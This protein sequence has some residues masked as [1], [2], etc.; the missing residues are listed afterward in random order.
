MKNIDIL[1]DFTQNILKANYIPVH[2]ITFPCTFSDISW[3][4]LGLRNDFFEEEI[5]NANLNR[6]LMSFEP[7][8]IYHLTDDFLCNYTVFRLPDSDEFFICG[9]FLF[10]EMKSSRFI[11]ICN[12]LKIPSELHDQLKDYY[13]RMAFFPVQTLYIN[14]F[15]QLAE[16]LFGKDNYEIV[17]SDY[18][19]LD[20]WYT[21]YYSSF[22]IPEK[23]FAA[24]QAI[25]DRYK[26]EKAII[27]AVKNTNEQ[28]ALELTSKIFSIFIPQRMSNE[29]RDQKDYL[30]TFNTLLGRCTQSS[31]VH[32][33]HIDTYSNRNV[34]LIEQLTSIEQC[35][36]FS[37]KIVRN[38]CRLIRKHTLKNY[39]LLTQKI[40]TYVN[41]D[42]SADLSLKSLSEQLSVNA[43]YLS[44]LFSKE[45][46]MSLTKFVN[47][48]RIEHAQKLLLATDMPIKSVAL[49]C[50]ISDVYYFSRLFKQITGT[51]PKAYRKTTTHIEQQEL[52]TSNFY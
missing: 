37:F 9:P 15:A 25:E 6:W 11:Q 39:S 45:I 4:D 24:L 14:L 33:I 28:K 13:L 27:D 17:Y 41:T 21:T 18:R 48:K 40:I 10:E 42:L 5:T 29:L 36:A 20:E 8:K 43:S 35:H 22:R 50:G 2:R 44:T 19:E 32:P 34:Q 31:G 1:I 12:R 16:F 3:L 23:P 30:I 7:K 51:T 52:S 49:K 26:L 38:Y 46:G 47:Q